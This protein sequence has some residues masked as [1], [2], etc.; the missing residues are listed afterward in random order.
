MLAQKAIAF[1]AVVMRERKPHAC[2]SGPLDYSLQ[3][4]VAGELKASAIAARYSPPDALNHVDCEAII[5]GAKRGKTLCTDPTR[6]LTCGGSG[7][8]HTGT[9]ETEP[10]V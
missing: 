2:V 5:K 6:T 9:K 3:T 8:G 1:S 10:N 7:G 4:A